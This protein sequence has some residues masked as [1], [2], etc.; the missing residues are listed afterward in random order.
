MKQFIYLLAF[1]FMSVNASA[2]LNN[3]KII[4]TS[5]EGLMATLN[6]NNL[7]ID[8]KS[9]KMDDANYWEV[10]ASEDGK[11][12][13]TIGLVMGADPKAAR[14]YYSFKQ[15]KNKIKPGMK[16]FRVLHIENDDNAMAS[17]TIGLTK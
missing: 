11:S 14:G 10:Q 8:W 1:A 5:I 6:G 12:F 2:Q 13:S 4:P 17:N 15:I 16:F 7:Q 9:N 3:N